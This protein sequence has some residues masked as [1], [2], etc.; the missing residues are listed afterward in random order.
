MIV[1]AGVEMSEKVILEG[2]S[3]EDLIALFRTESPLVPLILEY[4]TPYC[5]CDI[6]EWI[7]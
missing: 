3:A 2:R 4:F 7:I 1:S 6:A 5:D